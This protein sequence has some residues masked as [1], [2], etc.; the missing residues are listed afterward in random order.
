MGGLRSKEQLPAVIAGV[1]RHAEGTVAL[2]LLREVIAQTLQGVDTHYPSMTED[3]MRSLVRLMEV[4]VKH[5]AAAAVLREGTRV[6]L[7]HTSP[8]EEA[9][10]LLQ[11][12]VAARTQELAPEPDNAPAD[13]GDSDDD[14]LNP[15]PTPSN[16]LILDILQRSSYFL[17]VPSLRIQV[18][19][20]NRRIALVAA[21]FATDG[22]VDRCTSSS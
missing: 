5:A 13:G 8:L 15:P 22:S 7:S 1:L 14:D 18:R 3:Q 10:Q 20:R 11:A 12:Y 6:P 9:R 4:M 16:Q 19:P 2:P 21:A 17:S